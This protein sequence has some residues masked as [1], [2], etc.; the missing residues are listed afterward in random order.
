MSYQITAESKPDYDMPFN[1]FDSAWGIHD[2][3]AWHKA[4]K[5]KYGL[6][7]ANEKFIVAWEAQSHWSTP[8]SWWKYSS[9]FT[10]YFSSQMGTTGHFLS[11]LFDSTTKSVEN[12]SEGVV[13]ASGLTKILLPVGVALAGVYIYNTFLKPKS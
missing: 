5:A 12:V 7:K 9:D 11:R 1:I 2:W 6:E 3:I 10:N 13:N 4:L 8:Y